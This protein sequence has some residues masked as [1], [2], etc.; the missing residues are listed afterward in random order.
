MRLHPHEFI[1]RFLLHV[2][3]KG[4]HRIRHYGLFASTN[5]ARETAFD[6]LPTPMVRHSS[7]TVAFSNPRSCEGR[8]TDMPNRAR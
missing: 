4:F 5:R 2:L 1:R 3:P 8:G 7:R 6:P